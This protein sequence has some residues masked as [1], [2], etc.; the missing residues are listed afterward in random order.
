MPKRK[1]SRSWWSL[2]NA[3]CSWMRSFLS[4]SLIF[5][6]ALLLS[7]LMN[8]STLL[9]ICFEVNIAV[10]DHWERKTS[11]WRPFWHFEEPRKI[12]VMAVRLMPSRLV[13]LESRL[14]KKVQFWDC[15][16]KILISGLESAH[17]WSRVDSWAKIF[18]G[19]V[20]YR[21]LVS[22]LESAL[23]YHESTPEEISILP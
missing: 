12:A 5:F 20:L 21:I 10:M 16:V 2:L 4:F 7:Y 19:T 9:F 13:T 14:L 3:Q 8:W 11:R 6:N 18:S 17:P 22:G 1:L 23:P 15:S